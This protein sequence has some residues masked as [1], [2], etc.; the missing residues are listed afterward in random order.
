MERNGQNQ[1]STIEDKTAEPTEPKKE[2]RNQKLRNKAE[3]KPGTY[4][5]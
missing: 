1:Q 2:N 3:V 5:M 4:S